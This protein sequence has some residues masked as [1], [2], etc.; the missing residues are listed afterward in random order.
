ML[1][2]TAYTIA[3]GFKTIFYTGIG[4][5]RI[6]TEK[7]SAGRSHPFVP[8]GIRPADFTHFIYF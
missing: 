2:M 8:H 5:G 7:N 3:I 1:I 6:L 4:G